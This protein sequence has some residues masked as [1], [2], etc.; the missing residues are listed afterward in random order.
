MT[1]LGKLE[2][3]EST[4]EGQM[5]KHLRHGY[6]IMKYYNDSQEETKVYE[7][8]WKYG[9]R[10]G[11]GKEVTVEKEGIS[12]EFVGVFV[13][14]FPNGKGFYKWSNGYTYKG[15]FVKGRK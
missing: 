7:G 15:E 9:K 4:Y 3:S 11:I 10:H 12:K 13:N 6:G 2:S 1:N 14:G 5:L 8:S